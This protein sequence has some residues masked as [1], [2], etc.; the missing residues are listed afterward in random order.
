VVA[1]RSSIGRLRGELSGFV[2]RRTELAGIRVA[3][4][5]AR[6]VTLCGPGGI[7]KTRL[8]VRAAWEAR[9]GFGDGVWLV[10][11]AGL[12]DP[13]LLAAE[14]ARGVGLLDQSAG[15]AAGTLSEHLA[16]RQVLLVL[17]NCEHLL[18]ACAVLASAV[19]RAC[20]GVRISGCA[21][22]DTRRPCAGGTGI[23]TPGWP[24]DWTR[25]A[26]GS[27]SGSTPWTPTTRI[28]GPRWSMA[29]VRPRRRRPGWRW[30]ATCGCTG[31]P[32]ATSPRAGGTWTPCSPRR[33]IPA[34]CA[35]AAC[36]PPGTW[37]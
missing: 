27:W 14:V 2:G 23:S 11:L 34:R 33:R 15:W 5:G 17:D 22:P 8:A 25:S 9:R 16:G 24:P 36:G 32:A 35:A 4:G 13:A 19:L 26:P 3:L 1:A 29:S 21:R 30:P 12:R 18:D 6:L 31:T 20:P 7:G 10:E 37:R 28:C